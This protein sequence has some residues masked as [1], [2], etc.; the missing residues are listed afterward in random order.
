MHIALIMKHGNHDTGVGRYSRQL[1]STF[2]ELG[3][4]VQFVYPVVPLPG[5]LVTVIKNRL[6]VDLKS[7]FNNY[8][9]WA[10]YETADIYHFTSQNL[11][12]LLI[13][14]RPPGEII[15]TVHDIIPWLTRNNK[16]LRVYRN[17][18]EAIFDW[19]A[20]QGIRRADAILVDSLFT[21]QSLEKSLRLPQPKI[22]VI[23]L[24]IS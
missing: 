16:E 20:L 19:L 22:K 18:I 4:D 11:A 2:Q 13:F 8:P 6:G 5:R 14:H 24:G 17:V 12:T 23:H 10:N 7:F 21:Q 1:A 15:V 9:I 3:H